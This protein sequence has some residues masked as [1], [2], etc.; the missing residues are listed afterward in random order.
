M[1]K[2]LIIGHSLAFRTLVQDT[3][4]FSGFKTL[5]ADC[6][7][8]GTAAA[9]SFQP[10]LIVCDVMLPDGT[11]FDIL[12]AVQHDSSLQQIP[13]MFMSGVAVLPADIR[14]GMVSGADDYLLKPFLSQELLEAIRPPAAGQYPEQSGLSASGLLLSGLL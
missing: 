5:T 1:K 13:F 11:G 2:I 6:V 14:K 10:D 9:S 3:L 7:S 8:S 12:E 4:E